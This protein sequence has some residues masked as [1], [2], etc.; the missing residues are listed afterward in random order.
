MNK[1]KELKVFIESLRPISPNVVT[2]I[3]E[4]IDT[5]FES[6]KYDTFTPKK[7][8]GEDLCSKCGELPIDDDYRVTK[9]FGYCDLCA[10]NLN[11][12][13]NPTGQKSYN[14]SLG[15]GGDDS[16]YDEY[17][18]TDEEDEQPARRKPKKSSSMASAIADPDRSVSDEELAELMSGDEELDISDERSPYN[19]IR[20]T[21]LS[22]AQIK[23]LLKPDG[24]IDIP[25]F[26]REYEDEYLNYIDYRIHGTK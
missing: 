18:A 8:L 14:F 19:A 16:D 1:I 3:L 15:N 5:I 12:E 23:E 25:K 2:A 9:D 10:D 17:M 26:A 6:E 4:G 13:G 21:N 11:L 7:T 22:A 20:K 24:T